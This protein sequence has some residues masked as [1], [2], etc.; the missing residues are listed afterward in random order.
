MASKFLVASNDS[1]DSIMA[2]QYLK[3]GYAQL[4][5]HRTI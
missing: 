5:W 1:L 3:E 4:V 2:A